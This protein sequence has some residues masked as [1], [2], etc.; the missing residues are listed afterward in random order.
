MAGG[1][2]TEGEQIHLRQRSWCAGCEKHCDEA[3]EE[4]GAFE[5]NG[6]FVKAVEFGAE[7]IGGRSCVNGDHLGAKLGHARGDAVLGDGGEDEHGDYGDDGG[8][9]EDFWRAREGDRG[10]EV[11]RGGDDA[12]VVEASEGDADDGAGLVAILESGE[13]GWGDGEAEVEDRAEPGAEGEELDEAKDVG[14]WAVHL[15][16]ETITSFPGRRVAAI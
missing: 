3:E 8:L 2:P 10:D 1:A 12:K 9:D 16:R 6:D 4:D 15:A 11:E 7:G 5:A 14:H 13:E